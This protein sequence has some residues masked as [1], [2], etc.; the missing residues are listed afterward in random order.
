[1][2]FATASAL[3]AVRSDALTG[4]RNG[5]TRE[6]LGGAGGDEFGKHLGT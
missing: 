1:M 5:V 6:D 3:A 4:M 2:S